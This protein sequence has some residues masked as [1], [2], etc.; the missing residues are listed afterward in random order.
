MRKPAVCAALIAALLVL[1]W[2]AFADPLPISDEMLLNA[3]KEPN[4]WITYGRDYSNTR[5]SPLKQIDINNAKQLTA[6]W[7]FSFGVLEGTAST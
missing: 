6:Q 4:N 3:A 1:C 2:S 7:S 5:F